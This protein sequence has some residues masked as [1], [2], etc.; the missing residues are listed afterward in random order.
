[1][2]IDPIREDDVPAMVFYHLRMKKKIIGSGKSHNSATRSAAEVAGT[3]LMV[4]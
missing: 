2:I 1:M 4:S 3:A